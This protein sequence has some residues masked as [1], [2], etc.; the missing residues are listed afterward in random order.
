[1]TVVTSGRPRPGRSRGETYQALLLERSGDLQLYRVGHERQRAGDADFDAI[2]EDVLLAQ[3][4][5]LQQQLTP[6]NDPGQED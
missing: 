1:M 5:F 6:D 3:A 4:R 2:T